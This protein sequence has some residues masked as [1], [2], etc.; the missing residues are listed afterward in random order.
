MRSPPR[1]PNWPKSSLG[2]C[3]LELPAGHAE[4]PDHCN[5]QHGCYRQALQRA[6][7]PSIRE[8]RAQHS[9]NSVLGIA[10][11]RLGDNALARAEGLG[12]LQNRYAANVA[13][14][15]RATVT[16]PAGPRT[17]CPQLRTRRCSAANWRRVPIAE[18][19]LW[20]TTLSIKIG[21]IVMS[22]GYSQLIPASGSTR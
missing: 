9:I 20:R 6:S 21:G 18:V 1:Y 15:S 14:G 16:M 8:N 7:S 2:Y 13:V 11:A 17:V 5:G 12:A 19:E 10:R 3:L 4:I 22:S